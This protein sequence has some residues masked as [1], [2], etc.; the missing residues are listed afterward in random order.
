MKYKIGDIVKVN[1]HG[2]RCHDK[3]LKI[4][5]LYTTQTNR[6]YLMFEG[7]EDH[8]NIDSEDAKLIKEGGVQMK[9]SLLTRMMDKDTALI[10]EEVMD[11]EGNLNMQDP[12]IQEAL[13]KTDGFRNNLLMILKGDKEDK[14]SKK[15]D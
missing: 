12:R 1:Y 4:K 6:T 7:Y 11:A 5:K 15:N 3:I 9:S 8:I 13:L 2:H 14:K 10:Q